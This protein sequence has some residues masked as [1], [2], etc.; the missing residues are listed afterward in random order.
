MPIVDKYAQSDLESENG[1]RFPSLNGIGIDV[2]TAIGT[3][4][5]AATDD[6]TSVYRAL[7][8][9]P[10]NAVPISLCVH[11]DAITDGTDY[12]IGLYKTRSGDAVA[13]STLAA[14]LDM[15]SARAVSTVNNAGLSALSIA[16]DTQTL[17]Q[18]SGQITPDSSYD[19]ALT[20]NAVGSASGTI[21]VTFTY[22]LV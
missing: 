10:S 8:S 9:I 14:G 22:A 5:V 18:L 21:R 4:S 7:P 1:K 2:V 11:N 16:S 3:V 6:N 13:V 17:A 19:I 15:S 12:D 20:G